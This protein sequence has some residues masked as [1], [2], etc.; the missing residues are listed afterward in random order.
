MQCLAHGTH[1]IQFEW[2]RVG[3]AGRAGLP[4]GAEATK[5]G[6]LLM[7]HVTLSDSGVY[8]CVATNHIASS[9][10]MVKV[11]I[12]GELVV[13]LKK[14][15]WCCPFFHSL[16]LFSFV[17]F[18]FCFYSLTHCGHAVSDRTIHA[19]LTTSASPVCIKKAKHLILRNETDYI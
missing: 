14:M 5:D 18:S 6:K 8:K 3:R 19:A 15:I 1:P 10:A 11:V 9:E 17:S 2:S 12:K 4:A 13:M 16:I 7:A